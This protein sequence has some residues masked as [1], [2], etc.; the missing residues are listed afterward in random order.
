M[1]IELICNSEL[2]RIMKMV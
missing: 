2:K 1:V